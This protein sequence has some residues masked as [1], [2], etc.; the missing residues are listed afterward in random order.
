MANASQHHSGYSKH[1]GP[2]SSRPK[3]IAMVCDFFY[4]NTGGV[5]IHLYQ[6]S[7]C[8]IKRGNKVIL[9]THSYG[10]RKGVRYLTS[11]LKVYYL[12]YGQMY[13]QAAMPTFGFSTYLPIFRK[14]LI[15]E[16]IEIVHSHQAFS[17]MALEALLFARTMGYKTCFT[18]HSLFGFADISSIHTN[19]IIRFTLSDVGHVIC[20]SH[21]SKENTV[22]RANLDPLDVSVI[23]NA[24]DYISLTPDP[25]KRD[26]TKIT[27]IILSRLVY[28]KGVDL[29]VTV[30]PEICRQFPHVQFVIGGTGPMAI[31]LERMIE[32][33]CLQE[34]ITMLGAVTH[35]NLREVL[36]SGHIFLNCS[37]TEAFCIAIVEAVSCGLLCVSTKVGGVKEVLPPELIKLAEPC[38]E[39]IVAKLSEAIEEVGD[40][41]PWK[42][43]NLVK[44]M[45]SWIDIAKRTEI[46]YDRL[47]NEEPYPLIERL[48][49]FHNCGEWAGKLFVVVAATVY[50]MCQILEWWCPKKSIEACPDFNY[51]KWELQKKFKKNNDSGRDRNADLL[52][53]KQL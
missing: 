46:V 25:S 45:Y 5:E 32:K 35:K 23:P 31:N 19:K 1:C 34:R 3:R 37:L 24:V 47:M 49:R 53:V 21:T 22:I 26:P 7:T 20:V 29:M 12:V 36:I 10:N 17:T 40:F 16:R 13:N 27:V 28:R 38:T 50:I 42:A 30:I 9:I 8:L 14:I 6:L 15:R 39:D 11:G 41:D 43:H 48:C 44:E 18:D 51:R 4:P 2:P 52:R 33:N